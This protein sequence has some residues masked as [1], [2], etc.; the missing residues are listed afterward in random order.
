M[1]SFKEALEQAS[2]ALA[3]KGIALEER[4]K[5]TKEL[6]DEALKNGTKT[7]NSVQESDSTPFE[8]HSK[9]LVGEN[10]A[11]RNRRNA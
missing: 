2:K 5:Q 7:G 6:I 4:I 3:N 9:K 11:G 1:Q 10:P 8:K